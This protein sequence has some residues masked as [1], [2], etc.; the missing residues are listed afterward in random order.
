MERSGSN[1]IKINQCDLKIILEERIINP[2]KFL[3]KPLLIWRCYFDDDIQ[4]R[5]FFNLD[6]TIWSRMKQ[7]G[8]NPQN[9]EAALAQLKWKT[10]YLDKL[11]DYRFSPPSKDLIWFFCFIL[12]FSF[13]KLPSQ[14]T[15]DKYSDCIN[16]DWLLKKQECLNGPI[17]VYLPFIEQPEVFKGYDQCVFTPDFD[18]WKNNYANAKFPLIKPL[19]DYIESH[20][21]EEESQYYWYWYFERQKNIGSSADLKCRFDGNGCDFPSSWMAGMD[22]L[23]RR[24]I[25][26]LAQIPKNYIPRKPIKISEIPEDE[27]KAF[28]NEGI[29]EDLIEDFRNYLIAHDA[30][31]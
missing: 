15:Y 9:G 14:L 29:S 12:K 26:P 21:N 1:L 24:F 4:L 6:R 17:V 8:G 30:E 22:N 7:Q 5:V 16:S 31:V 19:M 11:K 27:F 28:F 2:K 23:M 13:H 20:I 25:P 10:V 18:A 3:D